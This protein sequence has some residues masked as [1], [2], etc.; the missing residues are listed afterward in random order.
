MN[1]EQIDEIAQK[2]RD[3]LASRYVGETISSSLGRIHTTA[4]SIISRLIDD[5]ILPPGTRCMVMNFETNPSE[6]HISLVDSQG[7]ALAESEE[8]S[9]FFPRIYRGD[10]PLSGPLYDLKINIAPFCSHDWVAVEACG[11]TNNYC[12]KCKKVK[13]DLKNV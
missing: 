1:T 12:K 11:V 10:L 8:A 4:Q 3:N 2:I 7:K 9:N 13:E 6:V 5:R